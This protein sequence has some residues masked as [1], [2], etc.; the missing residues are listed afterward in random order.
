[1]IAEPVLRGEGHASV[2]KEAKHGRTEPCGSDMDVG[3]SRKNS[4]KSKSNNES[5]LTVGP[6]GLPCGSYALAAKSLQTSTLSVI[7]RVRV[8]ESLLHN[9]SALTPS[10]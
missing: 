3:K 7:D 1:M 4:D 10:P 5:T 9:A 2:G 6:N 8:A